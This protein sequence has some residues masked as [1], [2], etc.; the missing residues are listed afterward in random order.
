MLKENFSTFL[1]NYT[2]NQLLAKELWTEI[3]Q[4]YSHK[5]GTTILY[6]TLKIY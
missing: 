5:K 4:S 2:D 1:K 6:N 3:E